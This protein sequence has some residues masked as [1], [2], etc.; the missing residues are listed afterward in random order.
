VAPRL[1]E[2]EVLTRFVK[3]DDAEV[4]ADIVKFNN[5]QNK[6]EAADFR[7]KDA[8]QD[9]LRKEFESIPEADY[10]GARRGGVRDAIERSANRLPDSAVAQALAA[11][12]LQPNLAYNETRRIW[13]EN[14]VYSRFFSEETSARNVVF[15][16]ALLR[17][18]EAAKQR[19][20]EIPEADRTETQAKHM[21]FFRRRGSITMMLAAISGSIELFMDRPVPN[22]AKLRF[23]DNC[24]PRDAAD[25]WQP[26]VDA[27]LSFSAQ[28]ID[29]TDLGLKNADTV[30]AS[31]EKFQGMIEATREANAER[32]KTFADKVDV[33][34]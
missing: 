23:K 16:Y 24:S 4:L 6:V 27:A 22:R 30:K 28:L 8:V 12:Q 33:A 19:I 13:E 18:L 15:A 14:A 10:R 5:T 32:Y 3:C 1:G 2:T 29:A 25:H 11:F 7:S 34:L 17:A 20:A 31:T 26:I 9:R 21:Q